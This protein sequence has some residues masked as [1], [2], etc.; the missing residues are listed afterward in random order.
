M[1]TELGTVCGPRGQ[2][3]LPSVG[4]HFPVLLLPFPQASA[5]R[6]MSRT[7][8]EIIYAY[9]SPAAQCR[10]GTS[11]QSPPR[12]GSQPTCAGRPRG[13]REIQTDRRAQSVFE[14]LLG[15]ALKN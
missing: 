12:G 8:T 13:K 9:L 10:R 5:V 2:S 3:L 14:T 15:Q 1:D 6:N 7:R 4:L 11:E